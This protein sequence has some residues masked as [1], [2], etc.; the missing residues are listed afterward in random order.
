MPAISEQWNIQRIVEDWLKAHE[1]EGLYSAS[2]DCA[3]VMGDL[4]PCC[5]EWG[6]PTECRPGVKVPCDCGEG[7]EFHVVAK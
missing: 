4:M 5:G 3:C 6:W 1:Y 7:C 2:E